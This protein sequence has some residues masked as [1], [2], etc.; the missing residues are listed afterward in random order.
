V[1]SNSAIPDQIAALQNHCPLAGCVAERSI[2][3]IVFY[4]TSRNPT[5]QGRASSVQPM[6][7][8]FVH[9]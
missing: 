3:S 8:S 4:G 1:A 6:V 5:M 9:N 2:L 7:Y